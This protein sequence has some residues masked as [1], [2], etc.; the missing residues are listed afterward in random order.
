MK[1]RGLI[2]ILYAVLYFTD[3]HLAPFY[4]LFKVSTPLAA[5]GA[6]DFRKFSVRGGW[7]IFGIQEGAGPLGG[8]SKI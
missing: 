3:K 4:R 2:R 1:S 7:E 8:G 6:G 5:G